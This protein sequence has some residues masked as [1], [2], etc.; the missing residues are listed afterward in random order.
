[1]KDFLIIGNLNAVTYKEVFPLIKEGEVWVGCSPVAGSRWFEVPSD[2]SSKCSKVING[3][4]CIQIKSV[5]L[6][7]LDYPKRHKPLQLTAHYTP[8]AYPRYDN[9]DAI[10]VSRT[11]DIPCDYDGV[12]GVP[13][14]FLDKYCPEQFEIVDAENQPEVGGA[15]IYKR[16]IIRRFGACAQV[17]NST[18]SKRTDE[19]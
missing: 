16:L 3:Q 19:Y 10:E 8:E 2:Y 18:G 4:K 13:I 1:M 5:W 15:R 14:S 6:T 11:E 12:M 7:T 17:S 9:Y